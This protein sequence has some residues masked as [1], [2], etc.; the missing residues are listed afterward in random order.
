MRR[1]ETRS[2]G[3][4]QEPTPRSASRIPQ[5]EKRVDGVHWT[6]VCLVCV[7]GGVVVVAEAMVIAA[8]RVGVDWMR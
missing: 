6:V 7:E 8:A 4:R 3:W 2:I 5:T 1:T